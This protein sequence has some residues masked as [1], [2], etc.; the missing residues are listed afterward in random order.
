MDQ[1][2]NLQLGI[3]VDQDTLVPLQ[4]PSNPNPFSMPFREAVEQVISEFQAGAD[5]G[6]AVTGPSTST[7]NAIPRFNGT[8]GDEVQDSGVT[9]DDSNNLTVPANIIVTGTV[10][11][12]DVATDGSKLDAIEAAAD[13]TDG[14]NVAAAG[15]VMEADATTAAMSFVIDE[16]N[17]ASDLATKVPTQQSVKAYVDAAGGGSGDVVGAASATD[18]AVA[19]Y[20]TTTGKLIQDS[21][22]VVDDSANVSHAGTLQSGTQAPTGTQSMTTRSTN[23]NAS[24]AN[25]AKF[26]HE[27]SATAT[28]GFAGRLQVQLENGSGAQV[29]A[30]AVEAQWTDATSGSEDSSTNLYASVAGVLT[31]VASFTGA[32][33][34]AQGGAISNVGNVDGRAVG[35]DG[36]KLD[37]IEASATA[38]QTGAEIKSAYEGEADTNAY[39]DAAV[40]KL[41]GVETAADVTDATNVAA[42]GAAMTANDLSD[43]ANAGTA[44]TNLGLGTMATEA[45]TAYALLAGRSGGQTIH[46]GTSSTNVLTLK[47]NDAATADRFGV[48]IACDGLDVLNETIAWP[49]GANPGLIAF[50]FSPSFTGVDVSNPAVAAFTIKP[51]LTVTTAQ[52]WGMFSSKKVLEFEPTFTSGTTSTNHATTNLEAAFMR[53]TI[54]VGSSGDTWTRVTG[55]FMQP[56]LLGSSGTLSLMEGIRIQPATVPSGTTVTSLYGLRIEAPAVSGTLTNYYGAYIAA[57]SGGV[58]LWTAGSGSHSRLTTPVTIGANAAPATSATLELQSTTGALLLNRMTTTQRNALTGVNGMLIY[59]SSTARF[60]KYQA[61]AWAVL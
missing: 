2:R 14:T 59:N 1:I 16:D 22:L 30:S 33:F 40:T 4:S 56:R 5:V 17:M 6:E 47:S 41:G 46:G 49:T 15:A 44:R 42:A 27:T 12:R 37:G 36:T 53:P 32:G 38:D 20:D 8:D 48:E 51:N 13:V 3:G 18:N 34:D 7:D 10:D 19:R 21:G 45:E 9:V 57:P 55:M 43:L 29:A 26:A 31:E 39:N 35:T 61:G 52:N 50:G 23:V 11:G 24:A 60:E 25:I 58:C 54:N 28:T